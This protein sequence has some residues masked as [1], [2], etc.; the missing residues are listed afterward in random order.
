MVIT[1]LAY[2]SS[3]ADYCLGCLMESWGSDFEYGVYDEGDYSS[4]AQTI[5]EAAN[6]VHR[7]LAY[8]D[9]KE[10]FGSYD[11]TVLVDGKEPSYY[12]EEN[13]ASIA[14]T[15]AK[16]VMDQAKALLAADK[17]A[18]EDAAK[19][20]KERKDAEKAAWTKEQK[21]LKEVHER[22]EYTRLK[23]KFEGGNDVEEAGK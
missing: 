17:K 19:T 12:M 14:G 9:A 23:T 13:K 20:E 15:V 6:F 18:K 1:V 3:G 5:T 21:R 2:R 7:Y 11:I 10:E 16:A 4:G 8:N 22:E